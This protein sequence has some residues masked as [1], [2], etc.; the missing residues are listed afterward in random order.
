MVAIKSDRGEAYQ[1]PFKPQME[2]KKNKQGI[3]T[4]ICL[5]ILIRKLNFG[6]PT[7]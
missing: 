4:K 2:D 7:A 6:F 5:D 1:T 3:N